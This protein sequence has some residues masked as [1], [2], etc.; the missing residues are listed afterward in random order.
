MPASSCIEFLLVLSF[1]SG[2]YRGPMPREAV[3]CSLQKTVMRSLVLSCTGT[4]STSFYAQSRCCFH[5][6]PQH[7]DAFLIAVRAGGQQRFREP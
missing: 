5:T 4:P 2:V 6:T 1:V 3:S 7:L